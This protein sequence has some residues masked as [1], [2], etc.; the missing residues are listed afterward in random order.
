[1]VETKQQGT[2]KLNKRSI[3]TLLRYASVTNIADEIDNDELTRIGRNVVRF[4]TIDERSRKDWFDMSKEA[5]DTATQ[6]VKEKN[7]PWPNASNVKYPV[8]TVAALQFHAR[9]YPAIVQGNKVVKGQITGED[10]DGEKTEKSKRIADFMNWQLLEENPDWESDVDGMLLA[11]PIEGCEFKKS[12]WSKEKGYN[13][14]EWVRP[15]DLIVNAA[16][17]TLES[18]PRTTHRLWF[19]PYEIQERQLSGLWLDDVNL[20]I[21]KDED[22]QETPQEFYEQHTYLDLDKDGY[23][24]PCI[25]TVHVKSQKV[26]RV[27]ADYYSENIVVEV[28]GKEASLAKVVDK[29]LANGMEPEEQ[30]EKLRE[31]KLVRVNKTHFFTKY[32]FLPAPDGTFYDMGFGQLVGPL[33]A[34]IDTVLNQLIDAGTLK[35]NQSGFIKDGV[36]VDGRRGNVKFK[37]GEY[38]RVNV[39]GLGSI[40]DA[41]MPF[42]SSE[43]SLAL[44]QLLGLLIEAAKEITGVQDIMIGGA[45]GKNESPTTVMARL[46]QGLKVFSAIYKRIYRASKSEFKKLYM[47]NGRFLEPEQYFNV[48]ETNEVRSVQQ[49]DFLLDELNVQPVADPQLANTLLAMVKAQAL[50]PLKGDPAVDSD[51]ITKRYIEALDVPN[52][53][54]VMIPP[55]KRQR[56]NP[57]ENLAVME[58]ADRHVLNQAKVIKTFAETLKIISDAEGEEVGTQMHE[59]KNH[60]QSIIDE[61]M[62]GGNDDESKGSA[63]VEAEPN[64]K[65]NISELPQAESRVL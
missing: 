55:E 63:A 27:A 26:V 38:K 1:M 17:K 12:Y 21:S 53:E 7:T 65:A 25:V 8:I 6:V 52:S 4:T 43:P 29:M 30:S 51:E 31:A 64:N 49:T 20:Q 44:F 41:I 47:L 23:K 48:L 35:N 56:G 18:C 40:R 11:L 59:Y 34:S 61:W 33:S 62:G 24:E 37:M 42:P 5:M 57:E 58:A 36:S 32:S 22:E 50:L 28:D 10:E 19:Y 13:V 45:A 15:K 60:L 9:A 54:S 16:T 14:S 2:K 39:G 3:E 46:E